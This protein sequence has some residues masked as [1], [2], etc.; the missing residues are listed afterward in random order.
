[1]QKWN[2]QELDDFC[3]EAIKLLNTKK[4]LNLVFM[5]CWLFSNSVGSNFHISYR[6]EYLNQNFDIVVN[7]KMLSEEVI[8]FDKVSGGIDKLT[9]PKKRIILRITY[10]IFIHC[11]H[12]M[13][14][15]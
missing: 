7:G 12:Q 2:N 4:K 14:G 11:K 6:N 5:N 9:D 15:K 8:S 10:Y 1:M 3:V 13:R